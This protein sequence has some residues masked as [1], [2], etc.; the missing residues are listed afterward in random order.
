MLKLI[1][2]KSILKIVRAGVTAI[3]VWYDKSKRDRTCVLKCII[4]FAKQ[5]DTQETA[6]YS[7][8][9]GKNKQPKFGLR[10]EPEQR[11]RLEEY[12]NQ[13]DMTL[14]EVIRLAIDY[15]MDKH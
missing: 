10:L 8:H 13:K 4:F 6:V 15:Y 12:A 5:L 11:Q 2:Y 9:M 7:E 1:Q 14:S 3:L